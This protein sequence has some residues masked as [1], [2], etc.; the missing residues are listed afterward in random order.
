MGAGRKPPKPKKK[1]S[2][3][4][5]EQNVSN[6]NVPEADR[7]CEVRSRVRAMVSDSQGSSGCRGAG[8]SL[9]FWCVLV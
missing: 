8:L 2:Y 6:L 9:P 4:T 7:K 1:H 5:I 3:K